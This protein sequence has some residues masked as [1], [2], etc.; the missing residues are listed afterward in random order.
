MYTA[1]EPSES[2]MSWLMWLRQA[3]SASSQAAGWKAA[4]MAEKKGEG[5]GETPLSPSPKLGKRKTTSHPG[6]P[7]PSP[8]VSARALAAV[9][10]APPAEVASGTRPSF[11]HLF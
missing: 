1:H 9:P 5:G 3:S 8:A 2:H 10:P 6:R 4:R 11:P 7:R